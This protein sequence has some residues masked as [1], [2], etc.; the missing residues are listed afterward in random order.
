MIAWPFPL[1]HFVSVSLS[2][3]LACIPCL[4]F[5]VFSPI[6]HCFTYTL[7]KC[8]CLIASVASIHTTYNSTFITFHPKPE[9]P[10]QQPAVFV[11]RREG[12]RPCFFFQTLCHIP[13]DYLL[14]ACNM[15]SP[16]PR[17]ESR[18]AP[19]RPLGWLTREHLHSKW[20]RY[21]DISCNGPSSPSSWSYPGNMK[22]LKYFALWVILIFVYCRF[23]QH[24]PV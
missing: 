8:N 21:L 15:Q 14:L 18:A 22:L 7:K 2:I 19:P 5:C 1:S 6:S 16:R 3:F 13:R 10:N 9:G 24:H 23:L 12:L 11:A 17:R 4:S 20:S